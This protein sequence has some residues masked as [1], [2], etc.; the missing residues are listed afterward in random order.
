M[1]TFLCTCHLLQTLSNH[2]KLTPMAV[3]YQVRYPSVSGA[4]AD[5]RNLEL[6][7]LPLSNNQYVF[8][9]RRYHQPQELCHWATLERAKPC[10]YT[11][12]ILKI[13]FVGLKLKSSILSYKINVPQVFFVSST[14]R[15][16]TFPKLNFKILFSKTKSCAHYFNVGISKFCGT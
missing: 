7:P 13:W 2:K 4:G 10:I 6:S 8:N 1:L 12:Y 14:L 15:T 16:E 9:K 11:K 3:L 5:W